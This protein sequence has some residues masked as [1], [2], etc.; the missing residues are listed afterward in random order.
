[1][2]DDTVHKKNTVYVRQT[3]GKVYQTKK[4]T[5]PHTQ[6]EAETKKGTTEQNK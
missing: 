6:R 1:M 2:D 4:T 5:R 3:K